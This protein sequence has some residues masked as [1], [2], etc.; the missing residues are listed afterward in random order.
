MRRALLPATL[1]LVVVAAGCSQRPK[2]TEAVARRWGCSYNAVLQAYGQLHRDLPKGHHY[3]PEEDWSA[4][5][6]LAHLG[7][8][9]SVEVDPKMV[10]WT[11]RLPGRVGTPVKRGQVLLDSLPGRGWTVLSSSW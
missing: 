4:C 11:Y 10:F 3:V 8:P 9:D 2:L 6:L 5:Q 7:A 1:F